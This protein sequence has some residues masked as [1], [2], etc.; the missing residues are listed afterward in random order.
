MPKILFYAGTV[1]C[2]FL[3]LMSAGEV[4]HEVRAGGWRS[5]HCRERRARRSDLRRARGGAG[6][7]GAVPAHGRAARGAES[8]RG[9]RGG[10]RG[11]LRDGDAR[12]G[13]AR[14]VARHDGRRSATRRDA[15]RR[16]DGP[17]IL[18]FAEPPHAAS[19]LQHSGEPVSLRAGVLPAAAVRAD[20]GAGDVRRASPAPLPS[21]RRRRA[22]SSACC[23][24]CSS[25][26]PCTAS[27]IAISSWR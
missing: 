18:R 10:G 16:A 24:C 15:F 1:V 7:R 27:A 17:R 2:L 4:T 3:A 5:R 25:R 21:R 13:A 12:R 11:Q 8:V 20:A 23:R 6:H 9:V 19:V 26:S 22:S 14:A